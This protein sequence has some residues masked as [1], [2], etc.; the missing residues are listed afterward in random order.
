[1]KI[2]AVNAGSSSIKF[3]LLEMPAEKQITSGIVERIGSEE[4]LFTIKYNGEKFVETLPI[5]DHGVGVQLILEGLIKHNVISN[6]NDIEGVGHR[7]VQ[8]GEFFKDSTIITDEVLQKIIDLGEMAP[9]HNP[10]NATGI[11]AFRQVLPH[12]PQVAVFDTVFHQTMTKDAYLYGTPYEWYTQYGIRKY[13][14]HGTSHQY[15]SERANQLMGTTQTKV[16]VCHIGNGAS[17]SAVKN[18]HCVET[19]MGFTPLEGFPMGTRSGSIDPAITAYM[20]NKLNKS[21]QDITDILNKKSGYLG[22]SG[23]SND[24]RDIEAAIEKGNERA[25][26]AFDIQAKQIADY[27]GSYY[28]YMGGLDAICFTAGIGENSPVLRQMI[29]DRLAV[30]GVELNKDLNKLRGERL[31]SSESSKVKVFIIPTDEEVMIAR[32]TMRL[33]HE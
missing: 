6:I 1:M 24:A 11:K 20:A 27:I 9:L 3:Q 31:I 13:G 33:S 30:L 17:L 32:D 10:A 21:A 29:I 7:V 5:K 18:G 28:V 26:L 8:G 12:V 2:M 19:S 14:F 23:L 16:V 4:A 25:R 15:V 22:I